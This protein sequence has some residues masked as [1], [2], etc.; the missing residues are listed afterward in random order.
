M[1]LVL[2][3]LLAV[4]QSETDGGKMSV[5]KLIIVEI[6]VKENT[7]NSSKYTSAHGQHLQHTSSCHFIKI[8]DPVFKTL[9]N[10]LAAVFY[11]ILSHQTCTSL[12]LL[13][14]QHLAWTPALLWLILMGSILFL[15][16][17]QGK[18]IQFW[19][20]VQMNSLLVK[21]LFQSGAGLAV[22]SL[23]LMKYGDM[24]H[25]TNVKPIL[26]TTRIRPR[27]IVSS[28]ALKVYLS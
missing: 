2:L 28:E 14:L 21:G 25:L 15:F 5:I 26:K 4:W 27:G 1:A 22:C 10:L 19:M 7:Y 16:S 13:T 18:S 24:V 3:L 6:T 9:G 8:N 12:F 20:F 17:F 23:I 11:N